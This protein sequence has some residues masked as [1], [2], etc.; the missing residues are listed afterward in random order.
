M[1]WFSVIALFK[2]SRKD[3]SFVPQYEDRISIVKARNYEMAEKKFLKD[4]KKYSDESTEFLNVY[5]ISI[6]DIGEPGFS[7]IEVAYIRRVSSLS[8]KKYIDQ[9]WYGLKPKDCQKE[10]WEHCW[11]HRSEGVAGCYN[12]KKESKWPKK[13]KYK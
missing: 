13:S 3:S 11:F 6:I 7:P 1:P 12:C 10:G 8:S 2:H 4:F 9:Y 5:E